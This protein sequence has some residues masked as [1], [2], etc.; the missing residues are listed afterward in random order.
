MTNSLPRG[1]DE[2]SSVV[3]PLTAEVAQVAKRDVVTGRVRVS[4]R[5]DHVEELVRQELA[6]TDVEVTRVPV[7]KMLEPGQ[8]P[9]GVREEGAVT[10]VPLVEEVLFVEKR[11]VLREEIHIA[12]RTATEFVETPVTVRRQR[13]EIEHIGPDGSVSGNSTQLSDLKE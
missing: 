9:P 3:L 11:L 1:E 5:T 4:T 13:A 6:R 12:R 8:A 10:I 7:D 2:D